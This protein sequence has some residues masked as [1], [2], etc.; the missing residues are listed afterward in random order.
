MIQALYKASQ[1]GVKIN[2]LV[3]GVCCLKPGIPGISD[4]IRV[5]PL[6]VAS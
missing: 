2:L 1:A 6:L 3:R 4:N 5:F